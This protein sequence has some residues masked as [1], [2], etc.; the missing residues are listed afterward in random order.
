METT[1]KLKEP[2]KTLEFNQA[3]KIMLGKIQ[4]QY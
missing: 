1:K 4:K 3:K 2:L